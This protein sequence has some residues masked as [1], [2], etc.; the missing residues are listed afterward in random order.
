MILTPV[1]TSERV[2]MDFQKLKMMNAKDNKPEDLIQDVLHND[3]FD[4]ADIDHNMHDRLVLDVMD[5]F[6]S[7]PACTLG[8]TPQFVSTV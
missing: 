1:V 7:Y 5:E 8:L 3:L 4:P 6:W 2:L